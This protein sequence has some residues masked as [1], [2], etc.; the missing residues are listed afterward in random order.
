MYSLPFFFFFFEWKGI[1]LPCFWWEWFAD[2]EGESSPSFTFYP[3]PSLP[4]QD[5]SSYT[6]SCFT[7][8][9][10][11]NQTRCKAATFFPTLLFGNCSFSSVLHFLS[12]YIVKLFRLIQFLETYLWI[13][14]VS[15]QVSLLCPGV[16]L[17]VHIF[18]PVPKTTVLFVGMLFLGR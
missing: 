17:I 6:S 4:K 10:D 13:S 3:P 14:S 7:P 8:S 9:F 1:M 12:H 11:P 18:S 2:M 16:T 15:L 5:T